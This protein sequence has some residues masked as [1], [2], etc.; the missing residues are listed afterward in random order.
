MLPPPTCPCQRSSRALRIA[1]RHAPDLQC[2]AQLALHQA[3]TNRANHQQ[4]SCVLAQ[5]V[6]VNTH[7]AV[8]QGA[9]RPDSDPRHACVLHE[10]SPADANLAI[11][12]RPCCHLHR[13]CHA[14]VLLQQSPANA[15]LT[16]AQRPARPTR[17]RA[18]AGVLR[19]NVP[20]D[21]ELALPNALRCLR[22]DG[23][24]LNTLRL[25]PLLLPLCFRLLPPAAEERQLRTLLAIARKRPPQR[26]CPRLVLSLVGCRARRGARR[27]RYVDLL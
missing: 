23:E 9:S 25:C 2:L 6:P 13:P 20:T 5:Q 22:S 3:P 12:Q 4:P 10:Q 18:Q 17:H 8:Q 7:L 26:E 11:Q 19:E 24:C 16:E 14:R 15:D 1:Q 27:G 21:A